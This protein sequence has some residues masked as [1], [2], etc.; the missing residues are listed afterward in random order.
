MNAIAIKA[1][2]DNIDKAKVEAII[3]KMSRDSP[4]YEKVWL[5]PYRTVR[6][7]RTHYQF[8]NFT[9]TVRNTDSE[10]II[11]RQNEVKQ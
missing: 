6:T 11:F 2:M 9:D 10:F 7:T 4:H 8:P 3:E 1:G 5:V